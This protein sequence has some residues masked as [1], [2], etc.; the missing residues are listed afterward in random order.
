MEYNN[1]HLRNQKQVLIKTDDKNN[2]FRLYDEEYDSDM[3]TE[4][5]LDDRLVILNN[6][7]K[8]KKY[9]GFNKY[10]VFIILRILNPFKKIELVEGTPSNMH[11]IFYS[12]DKKYSN[13][14][15]IFYNNIT[16]RVIN[17]RY[18]KNVNSDENQEVFFF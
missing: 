13:C 9:I 12:K 18:I 4:I 8:F 15:Y 11:R 2:N 17:V 3:D 6:S 14:I 7:Y 1:T 16:N 10:Y 5:H